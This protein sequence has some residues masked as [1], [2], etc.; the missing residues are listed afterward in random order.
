LEQFERELSVDG[1]NFESTTSSA[2]SVL[3]NSE[4]NSINDVLGYHEENIDGNFNDPQG[5]S[6]HTGL[7]RQTKIGNHLVKD[8]KTAPKAI[9]NQALMDQYNVPALPDSVKGQGAAWKHG[10]IP[11]SY[12]HKL[13]KFNGT[14]EKSPSGNHDWKSSCR[15]CR[16]LGKKIHS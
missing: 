15:E 9:R 5:L 8:A 14:I 7:L 12:T 10:T 4:T 1:A 2:D 13:T 11:C 6:K 16:L 3:N